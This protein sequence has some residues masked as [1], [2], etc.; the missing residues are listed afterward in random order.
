MINDSI[1]LIPLDNRPYTLYTPEQIGRIG[2][3]TVRTPPRE[4]LGNYF[5]PGSPEEIGEWWSKEASRTAA[6]IV[7]VPMLAYGGLICSRYGSGITVQQ[8]KERLQ[9]IRRIRE[10][11]PDHPIYA[12]DTITR[13][14]TSPTRD[15]PGSLSNKIRE[16]SILKDK[17]EHAGMDHLKN[18]LAAVEAIIPQELRDDYL[19]AR[20]RNVEVNQL[21]I[22]WVKEGIIDFL[23]IGQDDAEPY[24]LHRPERNKLLERIRAYG[25]G[26]KIKLFPGADVVASLLIAKR[27]T[28]SFAASPSVYVEYSR[29]HGDEWIAPFQDIV[30]SKVVG[31]YIELLGGSVVPDPNQAD[32]ILMANTAG[33][34]S[35]EPFADRIRDFMAGGR[36]VAIGDDARPGISDPELVSHLRQKIRFADLFGYSGWNIGVSI[37]QSV[38]RWTLLDTSREQ[39]KGLLL[40]SAKSHAELLL[41]ALAHEEAYRN[42][43][44]EGAAALARSLGDDP[45]RLQNGYEAVNAYASEH[46]KPLGD[47]WYETHFAGR[48]L[49][50]KKTGSQYEY[51]VI[52][53]LNG[54]RL[55]LPWNRTAELEAFPELTVCEL[56]ENQT[57]F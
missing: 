29:K 53:R 32:L 22:E 5:E 47:C 38:V 3:V 55:A 21:M 24:G 31:H 10:Q 30:Y 8:A 6:S 52:R 4:L 9:V 43:V 54:W 17:V 2:G 18:S 25:L 26:S 39:D 33:T 14:A 51:A 13:L 23:I 19:Q 45:Q 42:H 40:L 49:P 34:Q 44:R 7:A 1:S 57:G 28:E 41:E 56:A 50:L 35:V 48:K 27:I 12:F 20:L 37:A 46:T 11:Y 16:W 15:Y 36:H